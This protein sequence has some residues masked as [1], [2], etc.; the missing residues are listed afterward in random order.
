M[1][2]LEALTRLLVGEGPDHQRGVPWGATEGPGNPQ[3][4]R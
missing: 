3:A 1:I 2:Q 4:Q